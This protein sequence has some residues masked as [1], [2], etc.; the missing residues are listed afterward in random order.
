MEFKTLVFGYHP[1]PKLNCIPKI[2]WIGRPAPDIPHVVPLH[3]SN[4][5][6]MDIIHL[7][8]FQDSWQDFPVWSKLPEWLKG[9]W[10]NTPRDC[11]YAVSSY[12]SQCPQ[13]RW[14][15]RNRQECLTATPSRC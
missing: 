11:D 8:I 1:Y 2:A 14:L 7:K 5:C 10:D 4:F 6:Q 9:R 12:L 15:A 3:S 13:G